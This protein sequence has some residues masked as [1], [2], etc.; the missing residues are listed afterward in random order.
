MRKEANEGKLRIVCH[1]D[2]LGGK[3]TIGETRLP[4]FLVVNMLRAGYSPEEI[5][6]QYPAVSVD[7]IRLIKKMLERGEKFYAEVILP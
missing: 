1:P 5:H 7:T 3:P 2:R 6:R 4:F